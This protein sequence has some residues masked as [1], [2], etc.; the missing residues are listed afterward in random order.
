MNICVLVKP[1]SSKNDIIKN[2]D[3]SYTIFVTKVPQKGQV[4]KEIIKM[5]SRYF[6]K[7]QMDFEI[8]SGIHSKKKTIRV[9]D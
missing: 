6:H 7:P 4:N 9:L 5:F 2:D 3:G 8:I 1:R